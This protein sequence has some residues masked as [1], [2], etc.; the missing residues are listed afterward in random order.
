MPRGMN[1]ENPRPI[2]ISPIRR[3]KKYFE[4]LSA[5][6]GFSALHKIP[7][8]ASPDASYGGERN[9]GRVAVKAPR[10]T[11]RP[12]RARNLGLKRICYP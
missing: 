9:C 1:P 3:K 10:E 2:K 11:R 4:A 8:L 7:W 6:V 5:Q 12:P